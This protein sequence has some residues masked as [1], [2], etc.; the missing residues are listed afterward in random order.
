MQHSFQTLVDYAY[1]GVGGQFGVTPYSE[2]VPRWTIGQLAAELM[3]EYLTEPRNFLD[4]WV[5]TP[6]QVSGIIQNTVNKYAD[7][8]GKW[9][10]MKA[11]NDPAQDP[12][13]AAWEKWRAENAKA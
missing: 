4:M 13:A 5:E 12:G 10:A 6:T 11:P 9:S 1:I 3:G 7:D 2:N 8:L